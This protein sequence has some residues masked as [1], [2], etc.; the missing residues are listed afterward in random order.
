M[1]LI[2]HRIDDK[3]SADVWVSIAFVRAAKML[4]QMANWIGNSGDS[5][6]AAYYAQ[7]MEKR[8][9]QYAWDDDRYV[10]AVTEDKQPIGAALCSEG[11]IFALPQIWTVLSEFEDSE[12]RGI[13][14]ST[15]ERE[16][17][18]EAGLLFC[19]PPFTQSL[20]FVDGAHAGVNKN[21]GIHLQTAIWK[22]VSDCIMKRSDQL[23]EG[24]RKILPAL[25][26]HLSIA[27]EPYALCDYYFGKETEHR[28]GQAGPCWTGQT[29]QWLLY[30]LVK[31]IYGLQ[32]EFGG[33]RIQPC[34]PVSWKDC[35]VSKVFRE[36][37]YNIHYT[38]RGKGAGNVIDGIYVNGVQ[39]NPALP[40]RPQKGKTINVEV[41]LKS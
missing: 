3:K 20:D 11:A 28:Y 25:H 33:L 31:Y 14:I 21:G 40:I 16:L 22:L 23:E 24:L 12:R 39:V 18:T 17:N 8:V 4:S 19:K 35:S 32:P 27:A 38:Q 5:K 6:T 37:R 29:G 10:Y 7:E 9:Y 2:K 15:L 36:C 30:C 26:P 34:L 41:I 1:G 13:L